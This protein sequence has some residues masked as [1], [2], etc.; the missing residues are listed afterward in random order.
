MFDAGPAVKDTQRKPH[1]AAIIRV[2]RSVGSYQPATGLWKQSHESS[3]YLSNRPVDA[4]TAACAIRN[5]WGIENTSHH[6]RDVTLREDAS[7]I[8]KNPGVFARMRSRAS[9]IL[10]CNQSQTIPQD[11][12]AAVIAGIEAVLAMTLSSE[13]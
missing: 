12:F 3:I 1:V 6:A 2:E 9:N 11:R 8:R 5:H 10:R 7:R 4:K 13:R